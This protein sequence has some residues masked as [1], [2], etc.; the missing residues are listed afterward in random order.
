MD[1]VIFNFVPCDIFCSKVYIVLEH[2]GHGDLLE[3]IKLRGAFNDE[4]A[5]VIFRQVIRAVD[6][7]HNHKVVHR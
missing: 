7:M 2:A 6:Y 3:F 1:F 5:K 4:Q